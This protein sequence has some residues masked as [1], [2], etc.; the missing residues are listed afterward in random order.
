MPLDCTTGIDESLATNALS[1][2]KDVD[3]LTDVNAGR[4]A[5]GD[6]KRCYTPCTPT[7]KILNIYN[8]DCHTVTLSLCHTVTLF[9]VDGPD[10][11]GWCGRER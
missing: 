7:G 1:P 5:R 4:L 9:R 6:L 11:G 2:L 3:G 10:C 8:D